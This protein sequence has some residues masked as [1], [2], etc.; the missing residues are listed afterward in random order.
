MIFPALILCSLNSHS[1]F[2]YAGTLHFQSKAA[3]YF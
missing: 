1:S 3:M 2:C